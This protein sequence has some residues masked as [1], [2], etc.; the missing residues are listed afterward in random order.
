MPNPQTFSP[1]LIGQTEKALNA[2]L[3]RDLAATGVTEPQWVALTLAVGDGR[4][5][6]S[7]RLAARVAAALKV[8]RGEA[9]AR[10]REL[11]EAGLLEAGDDGERS[12]IAV[13]AAGRRLHER[14]RA[15]SVEITGRL[16]GDLPSTDLE[17]AAR[18]LGTIV[19]RADAELGVG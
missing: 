15:A 2:F 9:E 17:V 14:V 19:E 18:V 5:D 1:R 7:G 3:E 4:A 16:W 8:D 13:T 12:P 10:I 11:G 6:D